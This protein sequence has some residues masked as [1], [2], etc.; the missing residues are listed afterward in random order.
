MAIKQTAGHDRLGDFAPEFAHLNDDVLFGEVWSREREM[1]AHDRSLITCAGLMSMGLFPQLKSHMELAKRNGVTKTEMVELIT[2]LAFYAGWPKAWS[3]FGLAKET[4]GADE[5]DAAAAPTAE[6]IANH[7][8]YPLGDPADGPNFTGHAWVQYLTDPGAECSAGNV[9]FEPGCVNRWHT[10]PHG[11][12]LM[13]TAGRGWEQ[14]EGQE[15]RELKPGDVVFCPAGV[16]HWHGA[17]QDSS[18]THVAVT[19]A[20][21]GEQVVDW[22]EFPGPAAVAQLG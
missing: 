5:S 6:P 17:A 18:M 22:Q 21:P 9:T 1:S 10:H 8:P 11:Q 19:P 20:A 14:E 7:G 12:L 3:A 4:F 2:H 15:P 13:V 16:R